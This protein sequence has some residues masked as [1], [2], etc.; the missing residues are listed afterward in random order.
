MPHPVVT[1]D[2]W[3]PPVAVTI[4]TDFQ[5][6]ARLSPEKS[7]GSRPTSP[8]SPIRLIDTAL[9]T[10]ISPPKAK[11][12]LF[13]ETSLET[14]GAVPTDDPPALVPAI[15]VD[16]G[17]LNINLGSYSNV[18]TGNSIAVFIENDHFKIKL[19]T[20]APAAEIP[21]ESH[22]EKYQIVQVMEGRVR[23]ETDNGTYSTGETIITRN[24]AGELTAGRL[25]VI[26]AGTRH[27][28]V[29]V[30]TDDVKML[31]TY[32]YNNNNS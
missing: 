4:P 18:T 25:V 2:P 23:L 11:R 22:A 19:V 31:V 21:W 8:R 1:A 14:D 32:V 10:T 17:A 29:N 3:L 20:L 16:T 27:R 9:L 12:R 5:S 24:G 6:I 15:P 26:D 28:L 13:A 7:P 30:G